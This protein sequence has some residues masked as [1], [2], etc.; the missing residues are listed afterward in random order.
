MVWGFEGAGGG[1]GL[2]GLYDFMLGTNMLLTALPM[3]LTWAVD[4]GSRSHV[5]QCCCFG[6]GIQKAFGNSQ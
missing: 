4:R 5:M 3:T 1:N 2:D 6:T